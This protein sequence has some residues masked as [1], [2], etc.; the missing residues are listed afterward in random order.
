MRNVNHV[1]K[2]VLVIF[3][4]FSES[5]KGSTSGKITLKKRREIKRIIA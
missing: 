1:L 5:A 3:S 4:V 2:Y